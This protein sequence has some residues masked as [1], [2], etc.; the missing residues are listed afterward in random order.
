MDVPL[1]D[2]LLHHMDAY[3]RAANYLSVGQIHLLDNPLLKVPL[4]P[5]RIKP[6]LLGNWGT[7]PGLNHLNRV[8]KRLGS[9]MLYVTGPGHRGPGLVARCRTRPN[10]EMTG[11]N[12]SS[13]YTSTESGRRSLVWRD[14]L[15]FTVGIGEYSVEILQAACE[16]LEYLGVGLSQELNN[17]SQSDSVISDP[18][19]HVRILSIAAREDLM[20]ARET[21]TLLEGLQ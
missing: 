7:T 15:V 2:D 14:A 17:T 10:P 21:H 20:L 1:S 11:R 4:Q 13:T 6:R 16:W 19:I 9:N 18:E 5:K 12:W 3:W 8:I